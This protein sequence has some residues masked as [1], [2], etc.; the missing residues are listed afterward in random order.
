MPGTGITVVRKIHLPSVNLLFRLNKEDT[1]FFREQLEQGVEK[2]T[3]LSYITHGM[4]A[5]LSEIETLERGKQ[6]YF[7]C[8]TGNLT[9]VIKSPMCGYNGPWSQAEFVLSY[10]GGL[11]A[12]RRFIGGGA[13]ESPEPH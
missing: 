8:Y 12:M 6:L 2:D 7:T 13:I 11:N 3:G 4:S 5:S 9:K 1:V 10:N